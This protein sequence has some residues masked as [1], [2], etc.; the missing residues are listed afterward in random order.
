MPQRDFHFSVWSILLSDDGKHWIEMEKGFSRFSD[1]DQ[2]SK[3][4]S[5]W[6]WKDNWPDIR[7]YL[8]GSSSGEVS[9][10]LEFWIG[11]MIRIIEIFEENS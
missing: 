3:N 9:R 11:L 5:D 8:T 4:L 7:V 10:T 6:N 2:S 1:F